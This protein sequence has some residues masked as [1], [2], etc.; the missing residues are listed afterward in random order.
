MRRAKQVPYRRTTIEQ[1]QQMYQKQ[2]E[3]FKLKPLVSA[4]KSAIRQMA[5][6]SRA[7]K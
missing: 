3:A 5:D 1:F 6:E 2:R 7:S 4:V